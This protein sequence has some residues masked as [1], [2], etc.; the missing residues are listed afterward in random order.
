MNKAICFALLA[1]LSAGQVHAGVRGADPSKANANQTQEAQASAN[2]SVGRAA[3]KAKVDEYT[4]LVAASKSGA[5]LSPTQQRELVKNMIRDEK[6]KA[7]VTKILADTK[8]DAELNSLAL[9]TL[10]VRETRSSALALMGPDAQKA[11]ESAVGLTN[12]LI[13]SS[14][15]KK[16]DEKDNLKEFAK[17]FLHEKGKNKSDVDAME[18]A[19]KVLAAKGIALDWKKIATL[20]K[21][22]A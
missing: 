2:Q 15:W 12:A 4:K 17:S 9:E 19:S 6:I 22:K 11:Q 14:T 5:N 20:C 3:L 8:G 1:A 21:N 16:Q 13:E 7:D 18:A 10:S